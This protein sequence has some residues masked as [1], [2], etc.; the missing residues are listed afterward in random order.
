MAYSANPVWGF[1]PNWDKGVLERIEWKNDLLGSETFTEQRVSRRLTPRRSFEA[2]FLAYGTQRQKLELFLGAEGS[3]RMVIP[4]WHDIGKL[5]SGVSSGVDTVSIDTTNREYAVGGLAYLR[6]VRTGFYEVMTVESMTGSSLTFTGNLE[7]AWA[8]GSVCYPA[9][10]AQITDQVSSERIQDRALNLSARFQL[11]QANPSPS[12][13]SLSTYRGAPIFTQ[14]PDES[15]TLNTT[16]GRVLLMVDNGIGIPTSLDIA[17]R[18]IHTAG[19]RWRFAS[20]EASSVLRKALYYLAGR[21]R[22]IWLPSFFDDLTLVSDAESA[23][24]TI[25][26]TNVGYTANGLNRIG[27]RDICIELR[28]GTLINRR[29]SGSTVTSPTVETLTVST[30]LGQDFEVAEVARIS[31]LAYRRLDQDQVEI[32][33]LADSNGHTTSAVSWVTVED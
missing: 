31:Y 2:Q 23:D 15:E 9:V 3:S 11:L 26:V 5:T 29:V 20:R 21:Y 10:L 6:N 28:D 33:H 19:Y 24:T 18:P 7:N 8:A 13:W 14:R 22:A 1:F 16:F 32:N 25:E 30:S 4:L 27:Y 17:D 12:D